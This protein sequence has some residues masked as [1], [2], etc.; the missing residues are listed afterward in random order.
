MGKLKAQKKIYDCIYTKEK[1]KL[2]GLFKESA[3]KKAGTLNFILPVTHKK[4]LSKTEARVLW[5]EKHLHVGFKCGIK[6][7]RLFV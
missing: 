4:T 1:I 6:F 3:W 2:D 5:D 7:L